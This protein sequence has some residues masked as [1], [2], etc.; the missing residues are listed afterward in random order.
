[1]NNPPD[2]PHNYKLYQLLDMPSYVRD[3]MAVEVGSWI[4]LVGR[5]YICSSTSL[6][7]TAD[8]REIDTFSGYG[9]AAVQINLR[10]VEMVLLYATDKSAQSGQ[11]GIRLIFVE[12]EDKT[13]RSYRIYG[14][15]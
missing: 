5:K 2:Y 10:E 13:W 12:N 6:S 3:I 11:K 7:Q 15:N 4:E 9:R 14:I 8:I 1:M